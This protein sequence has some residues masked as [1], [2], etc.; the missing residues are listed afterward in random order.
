[1][2]LHI[3]LVF[4]SNERFESRRLLLIITRVNLC[5]ETIEEKVVCDFLER[6]L[7][8]PWFGHV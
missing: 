6:L 4:A 5:E 8:D 7:P 1:V 2:L 3:K